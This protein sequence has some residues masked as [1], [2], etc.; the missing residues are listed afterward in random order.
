MESICLTRL[1]RFDEVWVVWFYRKT[2]IHKRIG[3]FK[4]ITAIGVFYKFTA[5]SVFHDNDIQ[6]ALKEAAHV[7][8]I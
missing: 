4:N 6:E 1:P 7:S 3:M 5:S 8:F 2:L